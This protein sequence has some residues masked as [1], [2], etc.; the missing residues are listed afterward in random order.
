M[1]LNP[2]KRDIDRRLHP[3][4]GILP[5]LG[6]HGFAGV[7]F[8]LL[9]LGFFSNVWSGSITS[10]IHAEQSRVLVINQVF[11]ETRPV[12]TELKN[13]NS[14]KVSGVVHSGSARIY[15]QDTNGSLFL[16]FDS[17]G[18]VRKNESGLVFSEACMDTCDLAMS[19]VQVLIVLRDNAS[20]TLSNITYTYPAI[21]G[22]VTQ[23]IPIPNVV[24]GNTT[25]INVSQYFSESTN[26]PLTF[27]AGVPEHVR[28]V[29]VDD[30]L[31]LS[32]REDGVFNASITASNGVVNASASFLIISGN[33]SLNQSL[34]V[35]DDKIAQ[36]FLSRRKVPVIV[37]LKKPEGSAGVS[38]AAS[39][40]SKKRVEVDIVQ[41]SVLEDLKTPDVGMTNQIT[42][43]Q[44]FEEKFT[45]TKEYD[46]V[47]ALA[48]EV[49]PEA[50]E[51]LRNNPNVEM[52]VYDLVFNISLQ[53]ALPLIKANDTHA[54]AVGSD[55][56][57]GN[58]Q[59]VCVLDTGVDYRHPD[60][61]GRFVGG[62]DFV[63]GDTDALDDHGHG[64]HVSGIVARTAPQ[65]RIV[66]VKVCDSGGGC[67][68]STILS[69]IDYCINRSLELNISVMSGS[70][71]D[72]GQYD[73]STCPNWFDSALAFGDSLG[74]V[75][76]YAS[77]NN[78]YQNGINYPACSPF[79]ISVG[80]T[81]KQ[82]GIASFS[83]RGSRLDVFA[84]GVAINST[85]RDR[86]YSS[87]SGTSMAAPFVSGAIALLKQVVKSQQSVLNTSATR[88][89]LRDTGVL[90][91]SWPRIDIF[92]AVQ[93]LLPTRHLEFLVIS[94]TYDSENWTILVNASKILNI[95]VRPSNGTILR[96]VPD[97]VTTQNEVEFVSV[98]NQNG[99]ISYELI[100]A[101]N[102]TLPYDVYVIKRRIEQIKKRLGEIG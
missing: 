35:V 74:V 24:L 44:V 16:V 18:L 13:V 28:S 96:E 64:T 81:D 66:P 9:I 92:A 21:I 37:F 17:E 50:L 85:V 27:T 6:W 23:T 83:N 15:Y 1:P 14:L 34:V 61:S 75:S 98:T 84:P 29:V 12:V 38:D 2:P 32:F 51:D 7:I 33:A 69:G 19:D 79:A 40:L 89:A 25:M 82:D 10:L 3:P 102:A 39:V 94:N 56:V 47:N 59:S 8:C 93:R 54:V 42:G 67:T 90:V 36:E 22:I 70:L 41:E 58:G 20:L 57:A 63:N 100:D 60:L 48:V 73:A 55:F 53:D 46:T 80:A 97:G 65:A 88:Q 95:T 99:V 68:A 72:G 76:V 78:F 77:G 86:G 91:Q 71:G 43:A 26:H 52:I 4:S 11:N 31:F 87:L 5:P 49:T 30:S 101:R 62:I 45:V